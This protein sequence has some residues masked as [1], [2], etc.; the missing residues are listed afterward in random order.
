MPIKKSTTSQPPD[1][2][3]RLDGYFIAFCRKSFRWSPTYREALKRAFVEKR[4]GVEYYRC[5][6]CREVVER[7]KK[8]VDH[9]EPVIPIGSVWDRDWNE[10][11][12]RC[13]VSS[14]RVQVLCKPC[15]KEKTGAENTLRRKSWTNKSKR[16]SVSRR[17]LATHLNSRRRRTVT[18]V[19]L[20]EF[21]D[22]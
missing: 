1:W 4:N 22:M 18:N 17:V 13:F 14:D 11:R 16:K 15:H 9:I 19:S 20:A 8:Q 6:K 3:K 7:A 21:V 10:Y 2:N 12:R 5:E